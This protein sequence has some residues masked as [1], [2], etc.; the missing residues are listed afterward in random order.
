[1][2]SFNFSIH[3]ISFPEPFEGNWLKSFTEQ[4]KVRKDQKNNFIKV[5]NLN[6]GLPQL[7]KIYFN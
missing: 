1:M 3:F 7:M 2:E 5:K 4:V 6:G